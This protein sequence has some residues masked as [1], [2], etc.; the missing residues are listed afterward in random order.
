MLSS[1]V[2]MRQKPRFISFSTSKTWIKSLPHGHKKDLNFKESL[3]S[4]LK[5][6]KKGGNPRHG[7]VLGGLKLPFTS[8]LTTVLLE[9]QLLIG[10]TETIYVVA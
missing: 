6:P 7:L 9:I 4:A 3:I 8:I 2:G 1:C 10:R 5:R